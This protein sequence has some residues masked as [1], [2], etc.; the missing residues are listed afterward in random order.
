MDHRVSV[1]S[2]SQLLPRR[3][4]PVKQRSLKAM[5]C[6]SHFTG[7]LLFERISFLYKSTKFILTR[8]FIVVCQLVEVAVSSDVELPYSEL[9]CLRRA[10]AFRPACAARLLMNAQAAG[11]GSALPAALTQAEFKSCHIPDW[12]G[13]HG[14]VR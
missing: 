14:H 8:Y 1:L 13:I 5:N 4:S 3:I 7:N 10:F 6:S 12:P 11:D 9:S 2:A